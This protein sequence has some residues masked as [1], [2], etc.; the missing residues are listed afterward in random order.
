MLFVTKQGIKED[1][2]SCR[3]LLHNK[4]RKKNNDDIA[5][6]F[7]FATKQ[8]TKEDDSSCRHLLHNKVRKKKQR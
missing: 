3:H 2:S 7:F 4:V 5:I 8:G 1:D 6:I